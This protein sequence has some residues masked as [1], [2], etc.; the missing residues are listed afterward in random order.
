[1]Q[2]R[3]QTSECGHHYSPVRMCS[4]HPQHLDKDFVSVRER[5]RQD[6]M[7]DRSWRHRT[8]SEPDIPSLCFAFGRAC[9]LIESRDGQGHN[10]VST[11]PARVVLWTRTCSGLGHARDDTL[12]RAN[13][14][15][16]VPRSTSA[17]AG[18]AVFHAISI[19]TTNDSLMARD[20]CIGQFLDVL[21]DEHFPG[22]A[23]DATIQ[24]PG[25]PC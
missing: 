3:S 6:V 11:A 4:H 18:T 22:N 17:G 9:M 20:R 19:I 10:L 5:A 12:H 8:A 16:L 15:S 14:T 21:S 7:S 1:M 13:C 23:L 2:P 25:C 24:A